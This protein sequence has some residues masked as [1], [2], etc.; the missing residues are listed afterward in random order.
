MQ[1]IRSGTCGCQLTDVNQVDSLADMTGQSR[2]RHIPDLVSLPEAARILGISKAAAHKRAMKGQLVGARI[3]G[4]DGT[5]VFRRAL[6]EKLR[7]NIGKR[8]E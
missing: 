2:D 5:W 7:P 6:V 8:P 4:G 1:I 3:D